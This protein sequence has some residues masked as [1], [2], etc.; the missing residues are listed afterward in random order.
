MSIDRGINKKSCQ[1]RDV[2]KKG[3][4]RK[5]SECTVVLANIL[6]ACS[7]FL[8]LRLRLAT[9]LFV[10]SKE[11]VH[12]ATGSCVVGIACLQTAQRWATEKRLR[13]N[14]P[15]LNAFLVPHAY[16]CGNLSC[17]AVRQTY[18]I[19]EN[20]T[21]FELATFQ[22]AWKRVHGNSFIEL[23]AAPLTVRAL[24]FS[25][26]AIYAASLAIVKQ[27]LCNRCSDCR[28]PSIVSLG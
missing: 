23:D 16:A 22:M 1:A 3:A 28:V 9:A 21:W 10:M 4:K 26:K 7:L 17:K 20:K 27:Y 19:P 8:R 2:F 25:Q 14:T 5:V 18:A 24:N 15:R 11:T 6:E 12:S 13:R